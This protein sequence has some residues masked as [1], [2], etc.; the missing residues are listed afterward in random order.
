MFACKWQTNELFVALN[1]LHSASRVLKQSV[2]MGE[3]RPNEFL[4]KFAPEGPLATSV[5]RGDA[6][7][8]AIQVSVAK[9]VFVLRYSAPF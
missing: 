4:E 6:L 9:E 8:G 1:S 7:E 2:T 5:S 3:R